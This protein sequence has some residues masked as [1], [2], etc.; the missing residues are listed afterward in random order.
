[1]KKRM[2]FVSAI[3]ALILAAAALTGCGSATAP[4]ATT[5]AAATTAAQTTAAQATTAQ[6]AA[7]TQAGTASA[8]GDTYYNPPG[9]LPVVKEPITLRVGIPTSQHINDYNTNYQTI[10]MSEQTGIKFEFDVLPSDEFVT[11]IEL[12]IAAGGGDL[13]D[14]LI[15]ETTQTVLMPWA[16]AGMIL[17]VTKYFDDLYY[18]GNETL[19]PQSGFDKE[20]IRR[21]ITSY[22]GNIYG[23]YNFNSTS[24][25]QY[26]GSRINI[27]GPWL[28]ELDLPIPSTTDDFYETLVAFRDNDLNGTGKDDQIPL[29]GYKDSVA[30]LRKFLMTPFVYTQDEY[31]T[32]DNGNIGVCFN[33][34]EWREGL[35]YAHKL[36]AEGLLDP[37]HFT[38]DQNALTAAV[39]ASP[40]LYGAFTRISTSNMAADDLNRYNYERIEQLTN[41]QTGETR[42]S[43]QP[44][45]PK[46]N[47]F[48]TK[49]CDY[50]EAAYMWLDYM[51]GRDCSILTR[52]GVEGQE[53]EYIDK[54]ATTAAL[55]DFWAKW[56][57]GN[58]L[59]EYYGP[60]GDPRAGER[61]FSAT[62]W[63]TMQDTW[64]GQQGPN[65]M[66]DELASLFGSP[67]PETERETASYVNEFGHRYRLEQA[68]KLRDDSL[69]VAG[70]IY[71]NAEAK[72]INEVYTEIKL[73]VEETWAAYVVGSMDIE[74]NDAWQNYLNTL[75]NMGLQQCIDAAQSCYTRMN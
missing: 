21:Y 55:K 37:Q 48:I 43:I 12:M 53:W 7:T 63:G 15:R 40:Q 9:T 69:I 74:N 59:V 61:Y 52:Y 8:A 73:Y 54:D 45:L 38:Q 17:P 49:N 57:G 62:S 29:S 51:T 42:T 20:Y 6:E 65:V 60:N 68:M 75:N 33:T 34:E 10:F 39:S 11:K 26:S 66:T 67:V 22:D 27:Y 64:W 4:T 47:G 71:N 72:V 70:L 3:F 24:N 14:V 56:P 19:E 28:K 36:Y 2:R 23:V 58:L 32:A 31:W 35:R 30:S 16:E 41:S 50:P 13:S 25:N 18:W 5:T 1:M 46:L 44:A